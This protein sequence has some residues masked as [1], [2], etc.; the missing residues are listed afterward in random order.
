MGCTTIWSFT[1]ASSFNPIVYIIYFVS[2]IF[3]SKIYRKR[4]VQRF[5]SLKNLR[6]CHSNVCSSQKSITLTSRPNKLKSLQCSVK[7]NHNQ[8][9]Q[10]SWS[11]QSNYLSGYTLLH[12]INRERREKLF[13]FKMSSF[14]YKVQKS[15]MFPSSF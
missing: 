8:L 12:C 11:E 1:K 3:N 15:H 2:L 5:Y 13:A 10:E 7:H 6:S 14:I 4:G 9:Q